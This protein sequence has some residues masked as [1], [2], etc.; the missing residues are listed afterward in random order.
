[1]QS[2]TTVVPYPIIKPK[3]R[4]KK[5]N[6]KLWIMINLYTLFRGFILKRC[7][8]QNNNNTAFIWN[9]NPFLRLFTMYKRKI[10]EK[11]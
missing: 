2:D 9:T 5:K 6:E 11:K 7:Y 8:S 1:M 3:E 4:E 10:Y